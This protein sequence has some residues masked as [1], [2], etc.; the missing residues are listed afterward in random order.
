MKTPLIQFTTAQ[1]HSLRCIEAEIKDH[2]NQPYLITLNARSSQ[3]ITAADFLLQPVA[4]NLCQQASYHGL[5]TGLQITHCHQGDFTIKMQIEPRLV[6]LGRDLKFKQ[7]QKQTASDII[8][9]ILKKHQIKAVF[10]I[11]QSLDKIN[12]IVQYNETSLNFLHRILKRYGLCYYFEHTATNHT[13]VISDRIQ[14]T[15]AIHQLSL[16][17]QIHDHQ[18]Q[19]LSLQ[20]RSES[21][22]DIAASQ[23][24]HYQSPLNATLMQSTT[25]TNQPYPRK[26]FY[27]PEH[28]TSSNEVQTS[29]QRHSDHMH[30]QHHQFTGSSNDLSLQAGSQVMNS[31]LTQ[32]IL[33]TA[34]THRVVDH[35]AL[36]RTHPHGKQSGLN[37]FNA[38]PSGIS[39]YP[40]QDVNEPHIEGVQTALVRKPSS[41]NPQPLAGEVCVQFDW[42]KPSSH[43]IRVA[44]CGAHDNM[45]LQFMPRQKDEVAIRFEHNDPDRPIIIGQLYNIDQANA[46][47]QNSHTASGLKTKTLS[48][49]P[50]GHHII[51]DDQSQ[52]EQLSISS[53]GNLITSTKQDHSETINNNRK[54]SIETGNH[55]LRILK[56]SQTI[57]A[58][59]ICL[60][61]GASS[62]TLDQTGVSINSTH[63]SLLA[64]GS[65]ATQAVARQGD[66]QKCPKFETPEEPHV[67]G[68]ITSGSSNVMINGKPAARLGDSA[69]CAPATAAITAGASGVMINGQPIARVKDKTDH[70]GQIT[71]G[72]SNV[73]VGEIAPCSE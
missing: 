50:S 36:G 64:T 65:G 30:C 47:Y 62:I 15:Q 70:N 57:R 23:D 8:Q 22:Y 54:V 19:L 24:D 2:I 10:K 43:W 46:L 16:H 61:H 32:P 5:L 63:I 40:P 31:V 35:T 39:Q 34:V 56:G 6:L 12:S 3:P 14:R 9:T 29:R 33:L 21:T 11:K 37:Q 1:H 28:L 73:T 13:M 58:K 51:F 66:W 27:Y 18:P 55:S 69:Q 60:Q 67:G 38:I 4:I 52:Q 72:S 44:Q 71:Q 49:E 17:H 59:S 26:Y 41:N 42:D 48:T 25:G 20:S 45:G 53:S 7:Y 68:E